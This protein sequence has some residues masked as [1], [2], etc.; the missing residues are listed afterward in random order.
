MSVETNQVMIDIFDHLGLDATSRKQLPRALERMAMA[1]EAERNV[2]RALGIGF[3][4]GDLDVEGSLWASIHKLVPGTPRDHI[5][6]GLTLLE[7]YLVR[8]EAAPD[9]ALLLSAWL[10]DHEGNGS[11]CTLYAYVGDA[12]VNARDEDLEAY[13]MEGA[14][15]VV[16]AKKPPAK[17]PPVKKPPVKKRAAKKPAT[18]KP[19]AKK[20][21]PRTATT[22][23]KRRTRR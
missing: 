20:K 9:V 3:P 19:A 8:F 6:W 16:A 13:Q 12:A 23:P 15:R 4:S 18:K 11:G 14:L 2:Y 5:L 7:R 10:D 21:R 1:A 22:R 17:K